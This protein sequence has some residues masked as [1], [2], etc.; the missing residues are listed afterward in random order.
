L[1]CEWQRVAIEGGLYYSYD[2]LGETLR[3]GVSFVDR[4]Q[5]TTLFGSKLGRS[6]LTLNLGGSWTVCRNISLFGGYRGE[7]TPERSGDGYAHTGYV[8]GAWRW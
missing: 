3:S 8:G 6:V 5:S 7:V 1:R 2:M 4:S